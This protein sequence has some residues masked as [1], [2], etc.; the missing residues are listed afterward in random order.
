MLPVARIQCDAD[1]DALALSMREA[2]QTVTGEKPS[3]SKTPAE[4]LRKAIKADP[5]F[6]LLDEGWT[7]AVLIDGV[8]ISVAL[9]ID[10]FKDEP[11]QWHLSMCTVGPQAVHE[12]GRVPDSIA[13]RFTKA[14]NTPEEFHLEGAFKNLRHFRGVFS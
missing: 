1:L 9:S 11:K 7:R 5:D 12:P 4:A 6:K 13:G 3:Y 2:A 8:L 10:A 14:F